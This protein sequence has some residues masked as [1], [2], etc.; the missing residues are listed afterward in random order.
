[1]TE[2]FI[3]TIKYALAIIGQAVFYHLLI[4]IIPGILVFTLLFRM[5]SQNP[6]KAYSI[7]LS[8][9][10]LLFLLFAVSIF[11]AF[12]QAPLYHVNQISFDTSNETSSS[13]SMVFA[14][15]NANFSIGQWIAQFSWLPG[16]VW[17]LGVLTLSFRTIYGYSQLMQIR[18][19]GT[20]VL[21]NWQ[22]FIDQ[23][24]QRMKLSRQVQL[25]ESAHIYIPMTAGYLR[26]VIIIPLGMLTGMPAAQIESIFLHELIHIRR[27]D[28]VINLLVA[29]L[30]VLIFYHPLTW[31]LLRIIHEEREHLC[32]D[33]SLEYGSKPIQLAK[34]LTQLQ[35]QNL[36]INSPASLLTGNKS[37]FVHRVK[38]ILEKK[39]ISNSKN[40]L[41]VPVLVIGLFL[42]T[43][44][45]SHM[46]LEGRFQEDSPD[47][48]EDIENNS[49]EPKVKPEPA[50]PEIDQFAEPKMT[51]ATD[52]PQNQQPAIIKDSIE[53]IF[54]EKPR[55][56]VPDQNTQITEKD[57]RKKFG[58]PLIIIDQKEVP[59]S[60]LDTELSMHQSDSVIFFPSPGAKSLFGSRAAEGAFVIYTRNFSGE[61]IDYH[62]QSQAIAKRNR[63]HQLKVGI[64]DNYRHN[65]YEIGQDG[66][67]LIIVDGRELKK[68]KSLDFSLKDI[69][70]NAI[71]SIN[72]LK[73]A[74]ATEKYGESGRDGVIEITLK[75]PGSESREE[76]RD[77]PESGVKI[78]SNVKNIIGGEAETTEIGGKDAVFI[79]DDVKHYPDNNTESPIDNLD[80]DNITSIYVIKREDTNKEL[81]EDY[82]YDVII[83]KTKNLIDTNRSK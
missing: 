72:V 5:K 59:L 24:A 37:A 1:M 11:Y 8:S 21:G 83:I 39:N 77:K 30:K 4:S 46:L 6:K 13:I 40:P 10:V 17:I 41:V 9:F 79:I 76:N 56:E 71:E 7:A 29:T 36:T 50:K 62:K 58:S 18:K 63:N 12:Q 55:F 32:D 69:D 33:E 34:A 80:P 35:W 14:P 2:L 47:I 51:L 22:T 73:D 19:K 64:T 28:Y 3:Y 70:A 45:S 16:I 23:A 66:T 25:L 43:L 52:I 65:P 27:H 44:F 20:Q 15:H 61:K 75:K 54:A 42:L 48:V 31:Y 74:T 81:G 57:I 38:R 82:E 60:E 53:K 68:S 49:S 26:P 67:P 78:R